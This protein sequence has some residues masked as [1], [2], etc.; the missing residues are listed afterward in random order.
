[1]NRQSKQ[2]DALIKLSFFSTLLIFMIIRNTGN[3][4]SIYDN[5]SE[6]GLIF[7]LG[8]TGIMVYS[9]FLKGFL[10]IHKWHIDIINVGTIIRSY[11]GVLC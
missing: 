7:G 2:K 5:K 6:E 11:G 1:M 4:S 3:A 10:N 8:I 9:G